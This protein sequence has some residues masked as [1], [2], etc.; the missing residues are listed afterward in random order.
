[1][2]KFEFRG[3]IIKIHLEHTDTIKEFEVLQVFKY[4]SERKRSGI[5]IKDKETQEITLYVKGA[6]DKLFAMSDDFSQ[7]Y[8]L[9]L[10]KNHLDSF[11]KNGLR[12]L[13]YA[14][15]RLSR[16]EYEQWEKEYEMIKTQAMM[17]ISKLPEVEEKIGEIEKNLLLMG[18]SGLEDR[19]QDETREDISKFN[20]DDNR[21]PNGHCRVYW[22]FKQLL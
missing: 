7:T 16:K 19:L 20:V 1:M 13:C 9:K 3:K 17:D 22:I 2:T 8:L 6:D 11:A 12:T 10:T 18:V 5:I 15:K 14:S 21:R 4:S